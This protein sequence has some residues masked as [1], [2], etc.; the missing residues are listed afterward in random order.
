MILFYHA[1][2]ADRP[3]DAAAAAAAVAG[4]LSPSSI[5]GDRL[6]TPAVVSTVFL[7]DVFHH[8]HIGP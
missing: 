7:Y 3:A 5:D 8:T 1:R 6:S 4:L 2:T